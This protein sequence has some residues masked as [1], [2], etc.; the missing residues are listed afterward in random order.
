M[1]SARTAFLCGILIA[2]AVG[3]ARAQDA[4]GEAVRPTPSADE[5][6]PQPTQK[7][8]ASSVRELLEKVQEGWRA[9]KQENQRREEDFR[10]RKSEQAQLLDEAK[11]NLAVQEQRSER[12]ESE[13]QEGELAI[14]EHQE[15]LTQKLGTLGELFG[16]VRQVSGDTAG[17]VESSLVSAQFPDREQPLMTLAQSKALPSI[18]EIEGL[19][20]ALLKEMVEQSEVVRFQAPVLDEEGGE[21]SR[22]VVR[23]GVFNAVSEG[24]YLRWEPSTHRLQYLFNQPA[25]AYVSSLEALQDPDPGLRPV[26]IDPARGS[27]LALLIQTPD[28]QERIESG[29][30]I[31]YLIIALGAVTFVCALARLL[32]VFVVSRKV[33]A[34]RRDPRAR[35]DNP[36]GRVISVFQENHKDDVETLELKLDEVV[37]RESSRIERFLWAIKVVSVVSPLMGLLGTVTGMIKTFQVI[38]LFGAGDPKMMAGG[39]SE[40]LVTTMLGLSVAIP[41]VLLHSWIGSMTRRVRDTLNEQSAGLIAMRVEERGGA[42]TA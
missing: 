8:E 33:S 4:S 23:I 14:T 41:L 42:A 31:G 12:L 3:A 7:P 25:S 34:Q 24:R 27:I 21:E 32:Y 11:R 5:A 1:K 15:L 37:L 9:E 18:G 22:P 26:A 19:W 20:A 36:L 2:F 17:I 16:V 13:F 30:V 40:A 29:G 10:R 38:T 35:N 39:I 6:R 28:F